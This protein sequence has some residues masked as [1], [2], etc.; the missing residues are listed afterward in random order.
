MVEL[1]LEQPTGAGDQKIV[2]KERGVQN[3][4]TICFIDILYDILLTWYIPMPRC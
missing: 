3:G 4:A 2:G 1:Y